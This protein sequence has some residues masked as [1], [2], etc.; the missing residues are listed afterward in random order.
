MRNSSKKAVNSSGWMQ[1]GFENLKISNTAQNT[2]LF[3]FTSN[4]R[5]DTVRY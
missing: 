4:Y 1:K 3:D 5:Y 2:T